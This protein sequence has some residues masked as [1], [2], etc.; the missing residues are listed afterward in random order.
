MKLSISNIGWTAEQDSQ[1]Y[2][3]MQSNGF[4]GLEIAPTRIFPETPYDRLKEAGVWAE[5]LK[6]K[7]GFSIPSMQSI[8]Y[9]KQEKIFGTKDE[10]K[11]LID[12]TKKAIDFAA[13]I[14]CKN[15]VFGCPR[16]RNIP[17][18]TDPVG[19]I[20]FFKEIGNYAAGKGTV[21]G[22]E[23][24]PQIYNTNYINDT[25]SALE[26]IQQVDSEGFKLNFDL[27]TMIHNQENAQII[28]G[29]VNFINHVHVSE[30]GLKPIKKRKIHQEIMEI[31]ASEGY[32][33]YVSIEMGKVENS[34]VLE[35]AMTYVKG[36][37][38]NENKNK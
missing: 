32:Q 21:I 18:G 8:W 38:N 9:G 13:T 31:L 28:K 4:M 2:E 34:S 27:G 12:Y 29:N 3:L 1:I 15:L 23:A 35:D 17:D 10:F 14:D 11:V 19:G 26:L 7:Y 30:P 24:N 36:V 22:M 6:K 16:N 5:N 37:F 33:R 20:K 25:E